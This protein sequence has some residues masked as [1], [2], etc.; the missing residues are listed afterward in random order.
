MGDVLINSSL[1]VIV[2]KCRSAVSIAVRSVVR[3]ATTI[4]QNTGGTLI[5]KSVPFVSCRTSICS[6]IIGT[7]E[8]VG[9]N[10]YRTIGLR[11]KTA[12]YPRVGT[13]ASTRV[14]IITRVN[15]APRSVGVFNNFGMRN[16]GRRTTGGLVRR[17]R[18][19]RGTN[20]FTIMLRYI[21]TGLTGLVSRGV[22]VP[23]VNVN[24]KTSY[25]K[26]ILMGRSVLTVFSNFGP[27]FIGR[28]TS[29][30]ATVGSNFSTCVG[31][32]GTKS[33]PT[34]RRAFGVSSRIVG[35]LC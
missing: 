3:R 21:P 27:G 32:M 9:R 4:S 10:H 25:S 19:M 16:G 35:G 20:T 13:V 26:R 17:T 8:L 1:K 29:I 2:L 28:F 22:A 12:I 15:L 5:I 24:T 23:A 18:T 33:F 11:N 30:K 7:N 34:R 6:T 31:R 14:P